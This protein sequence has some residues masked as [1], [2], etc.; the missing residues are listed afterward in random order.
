[1]TRAPTLFT[2]C[3]ILGCPTIRLGSGSGFPRQLLGNTKY[4][5]FR[6]SVESTGIRNDLG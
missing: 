6:H 4:A 3:L 5:F 2:F 1:M